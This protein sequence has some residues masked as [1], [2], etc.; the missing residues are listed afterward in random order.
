MKAL[1]FDGKKAVY[2]VD[3]PMPAMKEPFPPPHL[4]RD[5]DSMII[6]REIM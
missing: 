2:K 6:S 3:A 4:R 1:Y 5:S